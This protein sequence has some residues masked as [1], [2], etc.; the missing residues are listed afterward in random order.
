M[1]AGRGAQGDGV[2]RGQ[3]TLQPSAGK[4]TLDGEDFT[5]LSPDAVLARGVSQ[6]PQSN[7]LFPPLGVRDETGVRWGNLSGGQRRM[8]EFARSLMLDPQTG[9]ARRAIAGPKP[10]SLGISCRPGWTW[11]E[12]PSRH[13]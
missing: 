9:A 5:G 2:T 13:A 11:P 4:S 8:V 3:R 10:K 12:R 1:T 6:V 7:G